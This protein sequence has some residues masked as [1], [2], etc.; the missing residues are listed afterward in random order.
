MNGDALG[1]Q[2]E[3]KTVILFQHFSKAAFT[4]DL[5]ENSM[6]L[7]YRDRVSNDTEKS[8][9]WG[10]NDLFGRYCRRSCRRALRFHASRC[11]EV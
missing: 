9:F 2:K 5:L 1:P 11:A 8:A 6:L 10:S 3:S 7:S 4:K